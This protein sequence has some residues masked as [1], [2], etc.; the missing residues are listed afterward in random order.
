LRILAPLRGVTIRKF[1]EVFA[2]EIADAGFNE[3][4][5]PFIS[6]TRGVDPL[7]DREIKNTAPGPLRV[8]P[9][10]I[11][12]DPQALRI[13]LARIKSA[14]FETADFNCGCPFPMV[15]NKFR[16]AGLL[17]KK[18]LLR[19]MLECGCEVM[20]EGRFSVKA[21]LGVN[22][23]DELLALM[24]L[25]NEFPLR[26]LCVH[27]RTARQMYT[28]ECVLDG[29]EA[30]RKVANMPVV[31]NGDAQLDAPS[32]VMIGRAFVRSLGARPDSRDLLMKYIDASIA[33]LGSDRPVVGRM[34]E[35]VSY[36]KDI[37]RWRRFWPV[38]KISRSVPELLAAI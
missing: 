37:P 12:K 4:V 36:W 26:F 21:R 24:P 28:G 13:A 34:K 38:V 16:G 25:F 2:A 35:L 15:R 20:G 22:S 27:A 7:K 30:V 3:V 1:R 11:G 23:P 31:Y 29:F 19:A 32:P 10:F 5:T 8:T 9:Q 6:V 18:D 14:G 17:L 33:E